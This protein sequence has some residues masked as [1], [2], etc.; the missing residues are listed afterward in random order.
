[1][2][3][4]Y[5]KSS[6]HWQFDTALRLILS[7]V[8]SFLRQFLPVW[9][10]TKWWKQLIGVCFQHF[11]YKPSTVNAVGASSAPSDL[12]SAIC[13]EFVLKWWYWTD[14]YKNWMVILWTFTLAFTLDVG[15][16]VYDAGIYLSYTGIYV[17]A[18][19]YAWCWYYC[20]KQF[21]CAL[22][23]MEWWFWW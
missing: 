9:Q 2:D 1:M 17:D 19:I 4:G 12:W 13:V 21:A 18:G 6:W 23:I 22:H 14:I 7:Q 15:I 20:T 10:Q 16:Y 8:F 3:Y 11:Y 5:A